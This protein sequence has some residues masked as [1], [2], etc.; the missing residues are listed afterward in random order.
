MLTISD[1][2]LDKQKSFIPK[3]NEVYHVP[4]IALNSAQR[5]RLDVLTFLIHGFGLACHRFSQKNERTNLV[6]F[7]FMLF[8]AK[9]KQIRSFLFW[10]NLWRANLLSVL[11]DL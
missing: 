6:F 3:K 9:N 4:W 11:Y 2:Y 7:A 5:W 1:F 10:E 8:M